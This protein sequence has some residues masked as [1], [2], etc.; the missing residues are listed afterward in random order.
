M[1][2]VN[3][4]IHTSYSYCARKEMTIENIVKVL[5]EEGYEMA[6]LT[7]H[8]YGPEFLGH[9]AHLKNKVSSIKKPRIFVG[10]ELDSPEPGVFTVS[11]DLFSQADYVMVATTHYHLKQAQFSDPAFLARHQEAVLEK[12]ISTQNVDVIAHPFSFRGIE[13]VEQVLKEL[14]KKLIEE[15]IAYAKQ[16][17][18]AFEVHPCVFEPTL[19]AFAEWFF[20]LVAKIGCKFSF[21][22]DAHW[23]DAIRGFNPLLYFANKVG[24]KPENQWLPI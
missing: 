4:H 23:L 12:V 5:L 20:S 2:K 24:L 3:F 1:I 11:P 21:G 15:L 9:V 14:D 13:N 22:T 17:G 19:V 6:G 8:V 10:C 7:D 18:I 16:K